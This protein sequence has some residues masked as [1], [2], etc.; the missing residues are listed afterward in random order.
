MT[1]IREVL[2]SMGTEAIDVNFDFEVALG[3]KPSQLKGKVALN[4]AKPTQFDVSFKAGELDLSAIPAF[5]SQRRP[6][7]QHLQ[8]QH[9][10]RPAQIRLPLKQSI[11]SHHPA[12][13]Q[14][15]HVPP[16]ASLAIPHCRSIT[17]PMAMAHL[18]L[19]LLSSYSP[20]K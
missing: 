13:L 8:N 1:S 12:R 7:H 17:C 11:P 6:Q 4:P 3:G 19:I 15:L 16:S 20:A 10:Q 5:N 18:M 9:L 2:R 14:L